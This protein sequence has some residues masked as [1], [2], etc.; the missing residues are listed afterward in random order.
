MG[1]RSVCA[2]CCA[3]GQMQTVR[4]QTTGHVH[5]YSIVHRSFPGIKTPF[6]SATIALDGGG[7]LQGTL[8]DV[9]VNT[10]E[11]LFRMA[12]ELHFE[13]TGQRASD[14]SAYL[15]YYFSPLSQFERNR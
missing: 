10:P 8:R 9:A 7:N 11:P 2:K 13:E 4:L 12:V 3:R 1:N 14:G 5:T 6:I 15:A